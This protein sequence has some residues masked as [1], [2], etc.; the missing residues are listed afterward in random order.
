MIGKPGFENEDKAAWRFQHV[1]LLFV[2][3]A[4]EIPNLKHQIPNNLKAPN[5][6][7]PNRAGS[8]ARIWTLVIGFCLGFRA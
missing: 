7:D 4:C 8:C 3:S 2:P 1:I 5:P 6:N